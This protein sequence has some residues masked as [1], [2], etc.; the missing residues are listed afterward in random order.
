MPSKNNET[1]MSATAHRDCEVSATPTALINPKAVN[2]FGVIR[3]NVQ[4]NPNL[5]EIES[6]LPTMPVVGAELWSSLH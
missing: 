4:S 3:S 6:Q 1:T 2:T 5:Y